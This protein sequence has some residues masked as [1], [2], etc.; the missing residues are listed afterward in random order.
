MLEL[1]GRNQSSTMTWI[2]LESKGQ[3]KNSLIQLVRTT[4]LNVI[5]HILFHLR[6]VRFFIHHGIRFL[7]LLV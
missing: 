4:E 5:N 1:M 2:K 7:V 3:S 6:I